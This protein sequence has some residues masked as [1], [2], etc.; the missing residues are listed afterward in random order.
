M[1]TMFAAAASAVLFLAQPATAEQAAGQP[2]YVEKLLESAIELDSRSKYAGSDWFDGLA[3]GLPACR[4]KTIDALNRMMGLDYLDK[5]TIV[6]RFEDQN[7]EGARTSNG[8]QAQRVTAKGSQ[9]EFQRIYFYLEYLK[10]GQADLEEKLLHE[11]SHAIMRELMPAD[12]YLRI[13][14]WVREGTAV[15]MAGQENARV[16]HIL[17][18][19]AEENPFSM[20]QDFKARHTMNDYARD[21]LAFR[22]L[23][24]KYGL[25]AYKT[26]M[27]LLVRERA[28]AEQAIEK[29]VGRPFE[30]FRKE[31]LAS[32]VAR[33]RAHAD[34]GDVAYKEAFQYYK[35]SLFDRALSAF[36]EV[37]DKHQDSYAAS[38]AS[39]YLAKCYYYQMEYDK[40]VAAFQGHIAVY[41]GRSGLVDDAKLYI[42][43]CRHSKGDFEGCAREM[44]EFIR[45]YPY[46]LQGLPK[47][48]YYLG[49]SLQKT[50]RQAEAAK[51]FRRL[52]D[53]YPDSDSAA[54]SRGDNRG[55]TPPAEGAPGRDES[56]KEGG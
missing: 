28:P 1:K 8:L 27:K 22:H 24:E 12:A 2:Q 14:Q 41:S 6:L 13:P 7:E 23:V 21:C 30:E 15:Y 33:I 9:G 42:G 29:A 53:V 18:L 48:Y 34:H 49:D 25:D 16:Q 11:M 4:S 47:A 20:V 45:D 32:A 38:A 19:K 37:I 40:A 10:N 54:K 39:Y 55:R 52:E 50:G 35:L 43:L 3:A 26:F 31:A 17:G 56:G 5:Y 44:S 51:A 36:A 46:S